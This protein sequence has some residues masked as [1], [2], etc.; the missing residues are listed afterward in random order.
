MTS[1][2]LFLPGWAIPAAWYRAAA[3]VR[4]AQAEIV[5]PGFFGDA[6][7]CFDAAAYAGQVAAAVA[8]KNDTVIFAHSLGSMFALRAA[9]ESA[10]VK[11]LV[12]FS[13]FA[14]FA[15]DVDYSGQ[16]ERNIRAM[17]LQLRRDPSGLLD[18]FITAVYR[19]EAPPMTNWSELRPA[20]PALKAGLQALMEEDVR[21][22]LPQVRCPVLILQGSEDAIS[23][24]G[25]A[26]YLAARLPMAKMETIEGVGH[27]L[28]LTSAEKCDAVID[29]FIS[30]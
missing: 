29:A 11:A 12:L 16:P 20:I 19:P 2:S 5:D 26:E 10:R 15:A 13:P 22:I 25:Q 24:D 14:R 1:T 9:A 28:P 4:L 3:P 30:N 7:G 8:N 21:A 6:G 18:N 23:G 17:Q 27:A